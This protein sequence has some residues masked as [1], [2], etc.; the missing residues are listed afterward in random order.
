MRHACSVGGWGAKCSHISFTTM[1]LFSFW[2]QCTVRCCNPCWAV[3]HAAARG[4]AGPRSGGASTQ[5]CQSETSHWKRSLCQSQTRKQ[6]LSFGGLLCSSQLD[7]WLVHP[8]E[9]KHH[10]ARL[11]L[12]PGPQFPVHLPQGPAGRKDKGVDYSK[13]PGHHP[14]KNRSICIP[15]D[16]SSVKL[17]NMEQKHNLVVKKVDSTS[18]GPSW[19]LQFIS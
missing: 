9:W 11:W 12:P 1:V 10:R 8:S 7:R 3:T 15:W 13:I 18:V 16:T 5:W 2:T 17:W 4:L 19:N 14:H 6:L